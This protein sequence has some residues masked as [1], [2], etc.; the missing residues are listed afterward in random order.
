M[1]KD[2]IIKKLKALPYSPEEYWLLSETA[3]VMHGVRKAAGIISLGCTKEMADALEAAGYLSK[4]NKP[5]TQSRLFD[6]DKVIYVWEWLLPGE[7]HWMDGFQVLDPA[8]VEQAERNRLKHLYP[9][10]DKVKEHVTE[11]YVF[12]YQEDSRA[13][14]DIQLIAETQERCFSVLSDLLK[15]Q[16]DFMIYY[17]LVN[18]KDVLQQFR[19]DKAPGAGC[20]FRPNMIYTV[21]S[22]EGRFIGFHEDTHLFCDLIGNPDSDAV[23]EGIAQCMSRMWAGAD[24][25]GWTV[26]FLKKGMF[27]NTDE[28]LVND[29]FYAHSDFITYP[30]MGAFTDW[31]LQSYKNEKFIEFY[32]Y[33]DSAEGMRKVY[34]KEPR[35]L[36]QMFLEVLKP[37]SLK[38]GA[39]EKL[40][41]NLQPA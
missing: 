35:E 7:F 18:T 30:I 22:D 34:G 19:N 15:V 39:E 5:G 3:N 8:G 41:E 32:K 11:H 9:D 10:P 40:D 36:N 23:S 28:L 24:N 16:P 27:L 2:E 20:Y 17:Y 33:K 6:I 26:W 13:E 38:E 12:R 37:L 21:Y 1:N 25:I 31:L 4:L 29:I 14:Q